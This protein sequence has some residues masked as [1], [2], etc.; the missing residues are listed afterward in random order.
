MTGTLTPEQ[1]RL[2]RLEEEVRRLAVWAWGEAS[3][4]SFPPLDVVAPSHADAWRDM[5]D[6]PRDGTVIIAMCRYTDG[7]AGFPDFVQFNRGHWRKVGKGNNPPMICWAWMSRRILPAW[8]SE[9]L[10]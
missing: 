5:E 3:A 7:A 10:R 8:P 2:S 4:P 6:A 1:A 9:P